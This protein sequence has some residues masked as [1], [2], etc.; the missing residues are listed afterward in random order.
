M[1]KTFGQALKEILELK[2]IKPAELSRLSGVTKQNIGRL[3]NEQ[4]HPIS[5]A[6]PKATKETVLKF[7]KALNWNRD[8]ALLA[9]G[10]APTEILFATNPYDKTMTEFDAEKFAA[11]LENAFQNSRFKSYAQLA[12]FIGVT[13]TTI[14]TFATARPQSHSG[15]PSRPKRNNVIAL[16]QALDEDVDKALFLAGH[17][18][19]SQKVVNEILVRVDKIFNQLTTDEARKKVEYL[20]EFLVHEMER[21]KNE[22]E[23]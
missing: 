18:P 14:S 13:R 23:A 19:Q 11:W 21:I 16:A 5:N 12:E 3:L 4:R 2:K 10:Y 7:A 22:E 6:P 9:A 20:F 8:E 15:K 1:N 17:A